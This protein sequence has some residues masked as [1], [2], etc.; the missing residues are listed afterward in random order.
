MT[1]KRVLD[2]PWRLEVEEELGRGGLHTLDKARNGSEEYSTFPRST[3]L[4][5]VL[6][7]GVTCAIG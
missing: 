6:S 1:S 2:L 4:G 5:Q 3:R 7:H